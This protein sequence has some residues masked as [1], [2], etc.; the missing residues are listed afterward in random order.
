LLQALMGGGIAAMPSHMGGGAMGRF[1]NSLPEGEDA[2]GSVFRRSGGGGGASGGGGGGRRAREE[3]ADDYEGQGD[4]AA[5]EGGRAPG[6][7][8]GSKG[9]R[10]AGG[11]KAPAAAANRAAASRRAAAKAPSAACEDTCPVDDRQQ[12]GAGGAAADGVEEQM[13]GLGLGQGEEGEQ[14]QGGE[15]QVA[16]ERCSEQVPEAKTLFCPRCEDALFCC[17]AC[18]KA[19]RKAHQ[20]A[21]ERC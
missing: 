19:H 4:A 6:G 7:A 20:A 21:G 1:L 15:Q 10:K 13:A 11:R 2:A 12:W 3:P 5:G 8:D 14:A 18:Q 16:C 9:G 17:K